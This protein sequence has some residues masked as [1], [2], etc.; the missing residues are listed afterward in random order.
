MK[1][2]FNFLGLDEGHKSKDFEKVKYSSGTALDQ[3]SNETQH[4]L[5]G[6][7]D[8]DT[9]NTLKMMSGLK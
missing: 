4:K 2:V 7:F 1:K 8:H 9:A 6:F 3:I 5:R